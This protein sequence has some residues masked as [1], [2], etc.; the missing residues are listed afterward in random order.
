MTIFIL[1]TWFKVKNWYGKIHTSLKFQMLTHLQT[2]CTHFVKYTVSKMDGGRSMK[3][4]L[5]KH[6]F[7]FYR[8]FCSLP[9]S[10]IY[11]ELILFLDLILFNKQK[12]HF[13]CAHLWFSKLKILDTK[14]AAQKHQVLWLLGILE[15]PGRCNMNF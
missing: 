8:Y 15:M 2:H 12:Q 7:S 3:W 6:I 11:I 9:A 14:V 4:M 13:T 10:S 5:R 1:E